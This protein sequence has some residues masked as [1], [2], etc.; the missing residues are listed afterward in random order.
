MNGG[1]ASDVDSQGNTHIAC[2]DGTTLK[3]F[4]VSRTG[5][6]LASQTIASVSGASA[7]SGGFRA[8]SVGGTPGQQRVGQAGLERH[9]LLGRFNGLGQPHQGGERLGLGGP[10]QGVAGFVPEQR[11]G[12]GQGLEV[13]PGIQVRTRGVGR[14]EGGQAGDDYKTGKTMH[15]G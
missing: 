12:V 6:V 9:G 3:Y 15:H 14:A 8:G 1:S 5:A 2:G 4:K 7:L 13:A 11:L 10:G